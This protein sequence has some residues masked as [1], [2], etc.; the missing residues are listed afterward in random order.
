MRHGKVPLPVWPDWNADLIGEVAL[1]T[2]VQDDR[3]AEY[4]KFNAALCS[5][6]DRWK[7]LVVVG[8]LAWLNGYMILRDGWV[9]T[10]VGMP[11]RVIAQPAR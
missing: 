5:L 4:G 11:D 6:P 10:G 3:H 2:S 1:G 8:C 9:G 7:H